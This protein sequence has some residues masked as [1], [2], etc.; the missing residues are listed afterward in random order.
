MALVER[1]AALQRDAASL[2]QLISDF[3]RW[4]DAHGRRT[5]MTILSMVRRLLLA[6]GVMR[7]IDSAKRQFDMPRTCLDVVL[8][9]CS[10]DELVDALSQHVKA[11]HVD[12]P[13]KRHFVGDATEMF[14]Q[15]RAYRPS[16]QTTPFKIPNV[17]F[18]SGDFFKFTFDGRFVCFEEKD[19]DYDRFDVLVDIFQVTTDRN[20]LPAKNECIAFLA[21]CC[22]KK[23]A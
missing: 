18:K 10:A 4:L 14:K 19:S 17:Y 21:C 9:H 7:G 11:G 5:T 1:A 22:R 15:L 2:D 8:R 6:L 12:F 13:F 3:A 16:V 23:H 20:I